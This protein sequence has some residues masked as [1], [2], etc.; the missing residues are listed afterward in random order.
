ML[1]PALTPAHQAADRGRDE[2]LHQ[3]PQLRA[4]PTGEPG[5][6]HH[7][8]EHH[9]QSHHRDRAGR[10]RHPLYLRPDPLLTSQVRIGGVQEYRERLLSAGTGHSR[11]PLASARSSESGGVFWSISQR[12]DS[13]R[14]SMKTP[15]RTKQ[16]RRIVTTV[17]DTYSGCPTGHRN[18]QK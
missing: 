16:S 18:K 1:V 5:Q 8:V 17:G 11:T 6:H 14:S 13:T 10:V 3:L 7:P 12:F 9:R 15:R 2:G 4:H